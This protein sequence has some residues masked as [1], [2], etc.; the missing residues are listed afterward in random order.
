MHFD[1]FSLGVR[2]LFQKLVLFFYV[3]LYLW[4]IVV[5]RIKISELLQKIYI[6]I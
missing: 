1:S 4:Y 5:F 6:L 3:K 2:D